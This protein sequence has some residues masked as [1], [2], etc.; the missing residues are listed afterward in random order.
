MA[1]LAGC[2]YAGFQGQVGGTQFS[3]L[4]S[5]TALLIL[6]IQGVAS[7][8]GAIL[9]GATYAIFYLMLPQWISNVTVVNAIQPIG[10]GLAALALI[11]HPE[12]AWP[13]QVHQF[14]T[15]VNRSRPKQPD[16]PAT[17]GGPRPIVASGGSAR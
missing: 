5:L 3:Y 12:G 17:R 9:G 10:I 11:R 16:P 6:A 1:G 15:L 2:F 4:I 13:A 8:P 14:K 7:V